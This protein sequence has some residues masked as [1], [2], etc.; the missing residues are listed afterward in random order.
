[1][2]WADALGFATFGVVGCHLAVQFGA[3]YGGSLAFEKHCR[4]G[5]MSVFAVF[6]PRDVAAAKVKKTGALQKATVQSPGM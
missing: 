1:M 2:I 3:P 5:N 4:L 6:E